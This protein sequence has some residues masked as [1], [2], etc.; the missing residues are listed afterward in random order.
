MQGRKEM[1]CSKRGDCFA[2]LA[3]TGARVGLSGTGKSQH[4][5]QDA[6]DLLEDLKVIQT[7]DDLKLNAGGCQGGLVFSDAEHGN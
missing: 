1:C 3:M 5:R 6:V 2:S 4:E 7:V